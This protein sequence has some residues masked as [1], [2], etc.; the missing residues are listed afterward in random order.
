M[1]IFD[2]KSRSFIPSQCGTHFGSFGPPVLL[3]GFVLAASSKMVETPYS[4]ICRSLLRPSPF[5]VL[6]PMASSDP[7]HGLES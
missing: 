7:L 1:H 5:P 6:D 2:S 4:T 3:V